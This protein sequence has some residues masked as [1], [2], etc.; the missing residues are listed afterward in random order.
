MTRFISLSSTM[1]NFVSTGITTTI[2]LGSGNLAC[3]REGR[4]P[5][6]RR[7][8]DGEYPGV[9]TGMRRRDIAADVADELEAER[10]AYS[11]AAIFG[12]TCILVVVE[13]VEE[14]FDR[15]AVGGPRRIGDPDRAEIGVRPGHGTR[16]RT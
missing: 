6:A 3:E 2:S 7:Q 8:G 16:D 14:R 15:T 1:R 9:P 12:R 13:D 4:S 11:G 5:G 10:Q